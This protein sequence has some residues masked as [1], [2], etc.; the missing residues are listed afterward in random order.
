[1]IS[2]IAV[3]DLFQKSLVFRWSAGR[4]V[5]F[6]TTDDLWFFPSVWGWVVCCATRR[7]P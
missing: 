6:R 5:C 3:N 4:N 1:M 7:L 2:S